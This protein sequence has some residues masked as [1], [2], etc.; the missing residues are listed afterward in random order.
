MYAQASI[1]I[2]VECSLGAT[3]STSRAIAMTPSTAILW[4]CTFVARREG[5]HGQSSDSRRVS[6]YI[7]ALHPHCM[8]IDRHNRLTQRVEFCARASMAT[9]RSVFCADPDL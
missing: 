1:V 5:K 2:R 4:L 7:C 9:M 6:P 3:H 8:C